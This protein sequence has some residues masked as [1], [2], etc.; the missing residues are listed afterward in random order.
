LEPTIPALLAAA[1]FGSIATEIRL[2]VGKRLG[3]ADRIGFRLF[4][5][6]LVW[7]TLP[8]PAFHAGVIW[9]GFVT[10]PVRWAHI[11]YVVDRRGRVTGVTRRPYPVQSR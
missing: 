8:I 1:A 10:S 2:A 5:H 9:G 11:R 4:Q 7:A 3:V 6:L